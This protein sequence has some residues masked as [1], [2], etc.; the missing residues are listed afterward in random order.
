MG[1]DLALTP[2]GRRLTFLVLSLLTPLSVRAQARA[3][4]DPPPAWLGAANAAETSRLAEDALQRLRPEQRGVYLRAVGAAFQRRCPECLQG[5]ERRRC[6]ESHRTLALGFAAVE[7]SLVEWFLYCAAQYQA[8][9]FDC[10]GALVTLA[11]IEDRLPGEQALAFER[12]QLQ[13]DCLV[14]LQQLS[15]ADRLC[16]GA[17]AAATSSLQRAQVLAQRGSVNVMLGRLDL[18][19]R[20][21]AAAQALFLEIAPDAPGVVDLRFELLQRRWDLLAVREQVDLVAAEIDEFERAQTA[22]GRVLASGWRAVLEVYR[23]NTAFVATHLDPTR[24]PAAIAATE[25]ALAVPDIQA[26]NVELLRLWRADLELRRDDFAAAREWLARA[27]GPRLSPRGRALAAPIAAELARRGGAPA[28]ELAQH[29]AELRAILREMTTTWREVAWDGESTGFLRLGTRLRVVGELIASTV[30]VFGDARAFADVLELQC[31]TSVSRARGAVPPTLE[32]LRAL[33]LPAGHGMLVYV[34]AWGRSHLFVLDRVHLVH[35]PLAAA[36]QLRAGVVAMQRELQALDVDA[37]SAAVAAVRQ[38]SRD[39]V[40][41]LVPAAA[42]ELARPWDHLTVTGANLLGGLSFG[43]LPW[44]EEQL[45]GERFALVATASLPL[46]IA[47]GRTAAPPVRDTSFDVRVFATLQPGAEFARRNAIE[48]G[49]RLDEVGWQAVAAELPM[50]GEQRVGA[51]ASVGA[52]LRGSRRRTEGLSILFAHGEPPVDD[53]PP[54]LGLAPD[55]E[56]DDGL[57][58]PAVV[59]AAPQRGVFVLAACEAARGPVR[60][61]DDDVAASM[62]GAFLGAGATAVV[63]SRASLRASIYLDLTRHLLVELRKTCTLAEAV[64]RAR[65]AAAE[66]DAAR[67]LL[68]GQIDCIGWD[69]A[70]VSARPR[71][72]WPWLVLVGGLLL[73]SLRRVRWGRR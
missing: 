52:W 72:W 27:V 61:G 59:A 3:D 34:P 5:P 4:A 12:R 7:P 33:L 11:E 62:A 17:A 41:T 67:A 66:G 60:M 28:S 1:R 57:L 53:Q 63:A 30:A 43:C 20:N 54:A 9:D 15:A 2:R 39:L 37:S 68:L 36:A 23:A 16:E 73:V 58:T 26:R 6:V 29:V 42:R 24:I 22:G 25:R 21:L 13:V 8:D 40:D 69:H 18:A 48:P 10:D 38:R 45:L 55:Q 35:V 71:R 46:L 47:L 19:S 32:E 51:A 64:R 70:M 49:T 14:Q 50:R 56:Y 31:C 44:T 65:L